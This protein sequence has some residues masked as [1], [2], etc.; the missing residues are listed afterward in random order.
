MP[1]R[2]TINWFADQLHCDRRNI[3]RIFA[4][5]NIDIM[6]LTRISEALDHDFFAD[7]SYALNSNEETNEDPLCDKI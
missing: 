4:K 5:D 1:K 7:L 6:L 3:Y 2:C